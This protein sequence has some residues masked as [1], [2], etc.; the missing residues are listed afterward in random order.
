MQDITA[1]QQA[2]LEEAVKSPENGAEVDVNQPA[3]EGV[4]EDSHMEDLL[5]AAEKA[6]TL[7][8]CVKVLSSMVSVP[9]QSQRY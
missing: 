9:E 5:E 8:G 2:A 3:A 6:T 4:I 1:I 7:W